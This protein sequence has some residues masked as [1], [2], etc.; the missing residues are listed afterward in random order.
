MFDVRRAR[1][2]GG[3]TADLILGTAGHID[4]GKTAL[5]RALTG[6]E[7]DRLPEEKK[8]GITIELGFASLEVDG[9]R[10]GIVDVPGH[11]RFVRNMLSGATGIDVALLVVAADDSVKPQTREH[12]DILK[13]LNLRHGVIALTKCD[14]ADDEWIDLVEAEVRDLVADTFLAEAPLVRTSAHTGQGLDQLRTQ[15]AQVARRAVE[16]GPANR[17][18]GPFRLAIDRVFSIAGHGTVVTGSVQ[19]GRAALG[20]EL[21]IEPGGIQVRIRGL[22]N[23]DATVREVHRGQRAAINLAG[24]HHDQ[25]QRGH[26][27]ASPGH[28]RPSRLLIVELQSLPTAPRPLKN[29]SRVRLHVGTA[30]LM[31]SVVLYGCDELPP[32]GTAL[33]MVFLAEPAV[34]TWGQPFVIRTES[35][36]V[37][38][39]G[40]RVLAPT[41][42]K[43]RRN[44][45]EDWQQ[46]D[47]LRSDN[48][49]ERAAAAVYFFAT[50]PWKADDL[51][52]A[53]GAADPQSLYQE[54][55]A[56]DGVIEQIEVSPTRTL[57]VHHLQVE[58]LRS[59]M[60]AALEKLHDENP[61]LLSL[62][63]SQLAT[64]F[65]YLRD[66]ALYKVLLN[67]LVVQR[68]VKRTDAGLSVPGRGPKLSKNE[69][70]LLEE[71]IATYREAG[72]RPPSVAEVQKQSAK[73]QAA[74]PQLIDMAA[75]QGQLVRL[76]DDILIHVE[77]EQALRAKLR[78]F[79]AGGQGRTVSE[80]REQ[81]DL[82]RKYAIPLCEYYDRIGFT[83]R[84]GDVR[85]LG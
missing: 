21:V 54:L 84:D 19:R 56:A 8:R 25:I 16:G 13:L 45:D 20:D 73:N 9:F 50:A 24:V 48:L 62:P 10:L 72:T 37:T 27:L 32:G 22:Q 29:R 82:T 68:R 36:V 60:V 35:P 26:E 12:L 85:V 15:L 75:G 77:A 5:I 76:T 81:L 33:A 17:D 18:T 43:L 66:D 51:A 38:I 7:T 69:A 74:V 34:T 3:M 83:K 39:G 47:L 40:G 61:L 59:R 65:E 70:K 80:I 53:A 14:V 71:I 42:R 52:R 11:E 31:A 30:E 64:Q 58:K 44:A 4:H 67:S 23:H 63:P 28:L 46:V 41:S 55:L 1:Y 79:M 6:T 78:E 2:N 57:R 49:L